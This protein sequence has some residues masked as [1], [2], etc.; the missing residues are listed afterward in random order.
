MPITIAAA[1]DTPKPMSPCCLAVKPDD[2]ADGV[3]NAVVKKLAGELNIR[4]CVVD[5]DLVLL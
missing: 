4:W 2:V 3:G 1:K 5:V